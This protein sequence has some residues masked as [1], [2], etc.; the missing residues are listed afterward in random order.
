MRKIGTR[1]RQEPGKEPP[2]S[3]LVVGLG[4][5]AGSLQALEH[6][7]ASIRPDTGFTFVVV[8]HLE[9]HHPS[10]LAELLGKHTTIP[11]EQAE[12]GVH[13]QPNHAYIIPPN[14]VLT[15]Q[16]GLL[17]VA[18]P[19]ESGL[20]APIDAF[21]RSLAKEYKESA[22]GI[23]VS[24]AG[25]DG[26]AGLRAIKENGGLTLAQTPVTAKFD[27][28]P[29]SAIAA[30]LVD[31]TLPVEQMAAR[32]DI[33]ASRLAEVRRKGAENL[34]AQVV[35]NLPAIC[36]ALHRHT[37]NDFSRYK[38]G[39][40]V[41][42]IR[43]RLQLQQ[44]SSVED[45]LHQVELD[46]A[47]AEALHRDSADR[48]D[49]FFRDAE[50]FTALAEE[51][52]PAIIA[53]GEAASA[54]RVWVPGCA[55]GE[56]AYSIAILICECLEREGKK[57]TVQLF[58]TDIDEDLLTT[59]RQG[60]Y[61]DKIREYVS[62]ERLERFF[63]HEADAYQVNRQLRELCTF[64]A[65]SLI[66]DPPFSSLDLISCRNL[67]I[68]LGSDLQMRLVPLFHYA[69][70][71][72]R[73]LLLGP[74]ESLAAHA[75]LFTL[76]DGK[77]RLFRRNES[78]VRPA[79]EFPLAGRLATRPAQTSAPHAAIQEVPSQMFSQA[80]E[81]MVLEEYSVSLRGSERTRRIFFADVAGHMGRYLQIPVGA[82]SN[83]ALIWHK[84]PCGSRFAGRLP[85]LPQPNARSFAR[86][87]RW[88]ST[89]A[90]TLCA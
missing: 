24:G 59:A 45:Y 42:R 73:F 52:L 1:S 72:G 89:A 37:G 30:G 14:A 3:Q 46:P 48:G 69:L 16:R 43:R 56:E 11:V 70:R 15:L 82:P 5:S 67:L 78:M 31:F 39:T 87:F 50:A 55:S 79:V 34:D 40:L 44:V 19:A 90:S 80:F 65:H 32:L 4:A 18:R 8:Q 28:M 74:S 22:V 54:L 62:A 64:S 27:S 6:F 63:T 9:R 76:V 58:A 17:R 7:F 13:I 20:R 2:R 84:V 41:R 85:R 21:L 23:I 26:T 83:N 12:D 88:K 86:G 57:R 66:K 81:R 77:A 10:V 47:E 71:P 29:Q 36:E 61:P 53:G 51:V 68:Y 38:Q 33:Y 75:E 49:H 35:A 60:R 25:T